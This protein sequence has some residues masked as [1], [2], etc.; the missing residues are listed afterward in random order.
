VDHLLTSA[1]SPIRYRAIATPSALLLASHSS[2][3]E[4]AFGARTDDL[5]TRR[6]GVLDH[7]EKDRGNSPRSEMPGSAAIHSFF[8]YA[9]LQVPEHSAVIQRSL[10]AGQEVRSLARSTSFPTRVDALLESSDT[11]HG[12]AGVIAPMLRVRADRL[13]VSEL[14]G[15]RVQDVVSG[16]VRT[17]V[18]RQRAARNAA[19]PCARRPSGPPSMA[20]ER[21]ATPDRAPLPKRRGAGSSVA[22]VSSTCSRSTCRP[23]G[24]DARPLK[25]KRVSPHVLRTRRQ[26]ICLKAG[27]T[28]P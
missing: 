6:S 21:A 17:P 2:T 10:D 12:P 23:P 18:P 25:E 4:G 5:D 19:R 16:R 1:G 13:R 28:A 9:A 7:I 27:A 11:A 15:L 22:T 20:S 14:V 26:W 8:Q 24:S 3:E